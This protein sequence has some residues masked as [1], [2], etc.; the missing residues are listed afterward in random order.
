MTCTRPCAPCVHLSLRL[1]SHSHPLLPTI[2]IPFTSLSF[3]RV[4]TLDVIPTVLPTPCQQTTTMAQ[5]NRRRR[6]S[7]CH[8][9]PSSLRSSSRSMAPPHT[10]TYG[11]TPSPSGCASRPPKTVPQASS[12]RLPHIYTWTCMTRL[13]L[14]PSPYPRARCPQRLAHRHCRPIRGLAAH[15]IS[16]PT[17]SLHRLAL[18]DSQ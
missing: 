8:S 17:S 12:S 1:S 5:F 4:P 7:P 10:L 18:A 15:S 14:S 9:T 16:P 3:P 13:S 6:H 2:V 11:T